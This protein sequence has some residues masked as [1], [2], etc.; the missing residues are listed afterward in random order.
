MHNFEKNVSKFSSLSSGLKTVLL[1]CKFKWLANELKSL[2]TYCLCTVC[3]LSRTPD[4][5]L[6]SRKIF[7]SWKMGLLR[8]ARICE[9][10]MNVKGIL[11]NSIEFGP[12]YS[13]IVAL[14]QS[15]GFRLA[16]GHQKYSN[17]ARIVQLTSL[18]IKLLKTCKK[19][20]LP[21]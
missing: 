1:K 15:S 8:W 16:K 2:E 9:L 19:F 20:N 10:I 18:A 12:C 11:W 3:S 4:F 13:C 5:L 6:N 21:W 7:F 17:V 14:V